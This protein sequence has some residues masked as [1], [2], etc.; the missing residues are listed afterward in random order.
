MN[1]S[2]EILFIAAN[3]QNHTLT[4]WEDEHKAINKILNGSNYHISSVLT[5]ANA[6]D[7]KD[8][9]SKKFW[10]IHFSGHGTEGGKLVFEDENREGFTMRKDDF[11]DWVEDMNGLRCVY[12]AA[13]QTDELATEIQGL[14]DYAIGFKNNILNKDVIEF[15]KAFYESL[16]TFETVP[17]AYKDARRKLR[18]NKYIGKIDSVLKSKYNTV[19]DAIF[20]GKTNELKAKY[21]NEQSFLEEIDL[22]QQDVN[23]MKLDNDPL[24]E[25][26]Q[27]LFFDLLKDSPYPRG[28]L[29][30]AENQEVLANKLSNSVLDGKTE[31]E[32]IFFAKSLKTAFNFLRAS[33]VAVDYKEFTKS[34]LKSV[35]TG[36]GKKAHYE[37]AFTLLPS[38]LPDSYSEEFKSYLR[39]NC[40][41][42][43]GLL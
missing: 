26:G 33:L 23:R 38:L 24:N 35:T 9:N 42:I 16:K 15:S 8:Y 40:N 7:L 14:V 12:L 32:Q 21:A 36:I 5:R 39:E 6:D 22:L 31:Y 4:E 11:L 30:F 43:K 25:G 10:L 1:K 37:N 34:D 17:L 18:R 29:W 19:M 41:Y 2:K 13:C 27:Q 20:T 28:T 3:P